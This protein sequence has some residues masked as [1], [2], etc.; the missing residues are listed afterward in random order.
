MF[1]KRETEVVRQKAKVV[2]R[3]K[4]KGVEKLGILSL[5]LHDQ[6]LLYAIRVM[7]TASWIQRERNSSFDSQPAVARAARKA[8]PAVWTEEGLFE[9][10]PQK[11]PGNTYGLPH[12]TKLYF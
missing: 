6:E 8:T 12:Y 7:S 4:A 11:I 5:A 1:R 3:Q 10:T 2:V 9:R